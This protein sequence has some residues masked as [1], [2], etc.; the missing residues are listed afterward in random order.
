MLHATYFTDWIYKQEIDFFAFS[1]T[2]SVLS[3]VEGKN[4]CIIKQ[5]YY[6]RFSFT[7]ICLP[8][9]D[10]TQ[11]ED[12]Y[13]FFGDSFCRTVYKKKQKDRYMNMI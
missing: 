6:Q 8:S 13:I 2:I 4:Y 1:A 3:F 9:S 7:F 5:T 10:S 11:R 12:F